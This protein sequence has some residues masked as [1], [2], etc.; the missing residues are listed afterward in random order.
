ML[1]LRIKR[2]GEESTLAKIIRM[3]EEAQSGKAPVARMADRVA[4]VFV[5]I[6]LFLALLTALS[7]WFYGAGT[8]T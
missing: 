2:I 4:G 3:V 6:V 7:W 5:P 8:E 1:T